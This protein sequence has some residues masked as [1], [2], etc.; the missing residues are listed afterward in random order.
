[1]VYDLQIRLDRQKRV[2]FL[3]IT[4]R[5]CKFVYIIIK[6]LGPIYIGHLCKSYQFRLEIAIHFISSHLI[7]LPHLAAEVLILNTRIASLV[8]K[9][10]LN[11][12][13]RNENQRVYHGQ[14]LTDMARNLCLMPLLERKL[15]VAKR[16][17]LQELIVVSKS[18]NKVQNH[19]PRRRV[20]WTPKW[21]RFL[22]SN[23]LTKE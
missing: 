8:Y 1:M 21:T 15:L 12:Y 13:L 11:F 10:N 17:R 2:L 3:S 18:S 19:K 9:L 4:L 23:K 22:K 7:A 16:T 20:F 5:W 14:C 6:L